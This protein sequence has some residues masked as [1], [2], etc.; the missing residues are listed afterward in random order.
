MSGPLGGTAHSHEKT[1]ARRGRASLF[2]ASILAPW[3]I[4][5]SNLAMILKF[6]QVIWTLR[7]LLC[8]QLIVKICIFF[9]PISSLLEKGSPT[10]KMSIH[11]IIL[12]KHDIRTLH[13]HISRSRPFRV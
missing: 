4:V 9:C 1:R 7:S 5:S 6:Y 12:P 10:V 13:D 2:G 11:I 3:L 8:I